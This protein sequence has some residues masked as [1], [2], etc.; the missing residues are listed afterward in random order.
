MG[1]PLTADQRLAVENTGGPLLVSAAAGAGKTRVLVERLLDRVE[2]GADIDEFLVITFTKA[3][4]AELRQRVGQELSKALALRPTDRHLRRQMNL[5]YAAHISTVHSFCQE[6]LRQWGHLL[7]LDPDFRLCDEGEGELLLRETLEEVLERHYAAPDPAFDRMLEV[8]APEQDDASLVRMVPELYQKLRSHPKPRQWLEDQRRAYALEEVSDAAQ[9]PW[10]AYLLGRITALAGYWRRRLEGLLEECEAGVPAYCPSL[11]VTAEGLRSLSEATVWETARM[12]EFPALGRR[13]AEDDVAL[14]ERVK[15]LRDACKKQLERTGE[16]L[17]YSS[18][19]LLRDVRETAPAAVCLLDVVDE[20]DDAYAKAKSRRG[21][22]DFNDLEHMTLRLLEEYP[23]VAE[24]ASAQ[25]AE[26]LVDEYQDTNGVQNAIFSCLTAQ[27]G[28]LFMVGDVKQSIYRFRQADPTIFLEKYRAYPNA[29]EAADGQ[30]RR[31]I[32]GENFRSR[33]QVID[34]VNFL[35]GNL[36]SEKMGELDY[37]PQEALRA[38]GEKPPR[39]DCAAELHLIADPKGEETEDGDTAMA[40]PRFVARRLAGLMAEHFQVDDGH[41]GTRTVQPGDMAIL[42]RSHSGALGRYKRALY[43]VGLPVAGEGG[44][45]L[46]AVPEVA[47]A[48]SYLEVIDNPHQDVPLIGVLRSPL[49]GFRPDHLARLKERKGEGRFYDALQGDEDPKTA[50][51]LADLEELR[52]LS[53]DKK[54]YE[55]LWDIYCRKGLLSLCPEPRREALMALYGCARRFESN[56]HKGLFG[57]L[58]H[59]RRRREQGDAELVSGGNGG[60]GVRILSIHGSKGLEY[61]VVAV[62]GLGKKFNQMD[63]SAD[64]L[65]HRTLGLGPKGLDSERRIRYSTLPRW[66]VRE[67]LE[68]ELRGEELR[69]LYVALTRAK[70]K[71]IMTCALRDPEK[72]VDRLLELAQLPPE[73]EGLWR[74]DSM[75]KWVLTAALCRPEAVPLRQGKPL[76]FPLPAAAEFGMMWRMELHDGQALQARPRAAGTVTR[77][78]ERPLGT[79]PDY[80]WRYPHMAA[81]ALPSKL[82]ATQLKGRGLDFEAEEE[83]HCRRPILFD[84]P[85]FAEEKGLTPGE[86]GTAHHV[87]MQFLDFSR[88]DSVEDIDAEIR[89]L[90]DKGII[91]QRQG[92]AVDRRVL[93]DFFRSELGRE[94]LAAGEGLHREFKFSILEQAERYWPEVDGGETVLLQGVVDCWFDTPEGLVIVDF[95]SDRV[96]GETVAGRAESYR[97]QLEAYATALGQLLGRPVA[98][99]VLWFFALSRAVEV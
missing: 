18:E 19:E 87:V 84:R 33:R 79:V 63:M 1:F 74:L 34:C 96:S 40:E 45:D 12:P 8:F 11:W 70:E 54:S 17:A 21:L 52:Q 35:F 99:R 14:A 51:F 55:L 4:A 65:F 24:E 27:R 36:M 86:R 22:L 41:G 25:F 68:E 88:T 78:E 77:E 53:R 72:E 5:L 23:Q 38:G 73:P 95:K 9:T 58:T 69:L 29:P 13:R 16:A 47:A 81:S 28:D 30:G 2:K 31:V 89:R 85:D 60:D 94:V 56:G 44:E 15:A 98:R 7:D 6:F 32:L 50:A 20:L 3:A 90:V 66:A 26:V 39:D 59:L 46:W 92:D 48:L 91:A 67:K 75:G 37:G 82:T 64:M 71:L 49:Y 61:P 97:P 57:F 83:A 43:E 76:L 93:W 80:T 42:L 10:G 62:A